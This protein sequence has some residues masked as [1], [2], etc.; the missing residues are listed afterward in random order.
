MGEHSLSREEMEK[1][2]NNELGLVPFKPT[3]LPQ[4]VHSVDISKPIILEGSWFNIIK[5]VGSYIMNDF[6]EPIM[7]GQNPRRPHFRKK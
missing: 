2:I 6:V 3:S 7:L 5:A 4:P 1:V